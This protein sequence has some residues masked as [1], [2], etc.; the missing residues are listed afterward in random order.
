[1]RQNIL[2]LLGAPGVILHE[3]GHLFFCLVSGVKVFR[4]KLFSFK[5]TAGFVE[6]AEPS[7]LVQSVLISFGPLTFNSFASLILFARIAS[8]YYIWQNFILAWL[9][10]VSALHSIP[11]NG[12]A[13]TLASIASRKLRHN[14]LALL[15]YPFVFIIY[16]LNLLKRL[17]LHFLYAGLLFFLG[18]I[19]LK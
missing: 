11:S 5:K 9:G 19:Y 18:N 4:V 10:F 17:H 8:P 13:S 12:D 6:H 3:L 2:K 1:M 7:S 15:C 16:C 14:P